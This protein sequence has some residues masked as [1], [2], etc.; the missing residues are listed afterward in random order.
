[1]RYFMKI[2]LGMNFILLC[3]AIYTSNDML[4]VLSILLSQL[5]L[6]LY[7]RNKIASIKKS[8]KDIG[9]PHPLVRIDFTEISAP[10]SAPEKVSAQCLKKNIGKGK[11][12]KAKTYWIKNYPLN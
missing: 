3:T 1:M 6:F 2:M 10:D 5:I 12:R 11:V 8:V 4:S 9:L 7:Q